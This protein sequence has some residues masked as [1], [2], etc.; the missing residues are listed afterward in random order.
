MVLTTMFQS[1]EALL[2][3]LL[4]LTVILLV[5]TIGGA[6]SNQTHGVLQRRVSRVAHAGFAVS[7]ASNPSTTINVRRAP[8]RTVLGE[9]GKKIGTSLPHS[10][11]LQIHLERANIPLSVTDLSILSIMLI[12]VV[13]FVLYFYLDFGAD[14]SIGLTIGIFTASSGAIG[15]WRSAARRRRF[16]SQFPDAIDL[17]VRGVRSGLPV[18]E[19]LYAV[20]QE[21]PGHVGVLFREVSA[22]I[23][24]GKS[25]DEALLQAA[26]RVDIQE[27][28]FFSI[29]VTIQQETGGN[30]GEILHNLSSLM[31]RREQIKLK[32]R[33]MSSEARASAM[34]I[35]SLPF[36][37]FL[38]IYA[39]DYH[40]IS[41]LFIDPRG[42]ML[43]G[44]GLSSLTVG[45]AV[46]AKMV[47]FEI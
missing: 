14:I 5:L 1:T 2:L 24:L 10:Q 23:K 47:R 17:I 7:K 8:V 21:F 20:G 18:T 44:A 43:L 37:M 13:S 11:A 3:P 29:S 40:Y 39:L 22:S 38:V 12:I 35:G 27:V 31:R 15:K 25:L 33:A 30:I 41:K 19:A 45:I 9:L 46:M 42:W 26:Q 36:I 28:Q 6:V 4:A 32:I 34:I 16:L